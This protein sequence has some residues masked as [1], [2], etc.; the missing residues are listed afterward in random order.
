M[1]KRKRLTALLLTLCL[2]F[3]LMPTT[4]FA[5]AGDWD[6]TTPEEEVKGQYA[7]FQSSEPSSTALKVGNTGYLRMMPTLGIG[8]YEY[9]AMA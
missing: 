5:E 6:P 4:A 3:T 1:L 2:V 7:G 9:N 8:N